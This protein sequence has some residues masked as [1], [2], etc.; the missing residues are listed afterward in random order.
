MSAV[1]DELRSLMDG[2]AWRTV[3]GDQPDAGHWA[4]VGAEQFPA[5]V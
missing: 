2:T 1:L 3:S 5:V 4:T